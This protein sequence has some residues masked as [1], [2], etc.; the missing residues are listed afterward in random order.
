MATTDPMPEYGADSNQQL[1]L[2]LGIESYV[3]SDA[4]QPNK[5][6][7]GANASVDLASLSNLDNKP[8]LTKRLRWGI[9]LRNGDLTPQAQ[10]ERLQELQLAL[11]SNQQQMQDELRQ[12]YAQNQQQS[13]RIHQLEQALDQALSYVE[14]L[15]QQVQDQQRLEEQLAVT[16]EY[17]NVQQQAIIRLKQ[18]LAEQSAE[19]LATAQS[20]PKDVEPFTSAAPTKQNSIARLDSYSL[21]SE[22]AGDLAKV[23]AAAQAHIESLSTEIEERTTFQA[24]LQHTCQEIMT[25]RDQLCN[26]MATIE[27]QNAELQEQILKQMKQ[28]SDYETGLRHWKE[29]YMATQQQFGQLK[30]VLKTALTHP[31]AH[32]MFG[33]NAEQLLAELQAPSWERDLNLPTSQQTSFQPSRPAAAPPA[34]IPPM[35]VS[36]SPSS[37]LS[38]FLRRLRGLP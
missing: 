29:R 18:R 2:N 38:D 31:A 24:R 21:S 30:Q 28:I 15:R 1:S 10:I 23:I 17:A 9:P 20:P 8:N 5:G 13:K 3:T 14:D 35:Q 22:F 25:E 36:D 11:E 4:I 32:Q 12:A 16:E 26:R 34:G 19:H 7:L 37:G 27:Q 33:Q 6:K